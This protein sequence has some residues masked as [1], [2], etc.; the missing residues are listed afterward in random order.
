M[1]Y[2]P[3]TAAIF[4]ELWDAR[5]IRAD[6]QLERVDNT[7]YWLGRQLSRHEITRDDVNRRLDALCAHRPWDD[8]A[9]CPWHLAQ[10][11]ATDALRRGMEATR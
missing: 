10:P 1:S 8:D 5:L 9:W 4:D 3:E 7:A 6:A 2:D 11:A